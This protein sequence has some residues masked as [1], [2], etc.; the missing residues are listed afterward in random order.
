MIGNLPLTV[1]KIAEALLSVKGEKTFDESLWECMGYVGDCTRAN[2]VY[3]WRADRREYTLFRTY[4]W[5]E[6]DGDNFVRVNDRYELKQDMFEA[7]Q[8][9]FLHNKA[10][11]GNVIDL[12]DECRE[13]F[14]E[15]NHNE[16]ISGTAI[17]LFL[18]GEFWGLFTIEHCTNEYIYSE[19][20]I[21]LLASVGLMIANSIERQDIMSR[22]STE[23]EDAR[24]VFHRYRAILDA[25]PMPITVVDTE[26]KWTFINKAVESL[27][28]IKQCDAVGMKCSTWGRSICNSD[29]CAV[30]RFERGEPGSYFSENNF[31]YRVECSAILDTDGEKMGYVELVQDITQL[32]TMMKRHAEADN[33]N[34]AKSAFLAAMSHEIR[35]P[36]NIILGISEIEM[37]KPSNLP[38]TIEAFGQ[39]RD[40]GELLLALVNDILDISKIEAG[41]ME[42]S[43]NVYTVPTVI[44]ESARLNYMRFE[45]KPI[46]FNI[47]F[48]ENSPCELLGDEL[49]IKQVLN[50]ILSNAF[51]YTDKGEVNLSVAVECPYG[52]VIDADAFLVIVVSD[53]GQG[54]D[55]SQAK[56]C[57]E[58]FTRF[59][60]KANNGIEGTGLG[61][62]ITKKLVITMGG[63]IELDSEPG[64]GSTFTVRIPQK[65]KSDKMSGAEASGKLK[66][67]ALI[68]GARMSAPPMNAIAST[69]ESKPSETM[70]H[71]RVLV[72]D[73][74][75]SNLLVA[76][77]FLNP[78]GVT[79]ETATSAKE[80]FAR[81][82]DEGEYDIIFMDHMMPDI[83]GI[84]ATEKLRKS[85]YSKPIVALTANAIHGQREFFLENGFDEFITKPICSKALRELMFKFINIHETP[86]LPAISKE[87]SVIDI[88]EIKKYFIRDAG[89]AVT[90][91]KEFLAEAEPRHKD[92]KNFTVSAH[93]MKAVLSTI[94]E[95]HLSKE[96]AT[97]EAAGNVRD[98]S[99]IHA[100]TPAM[101]IRLT[102]LLKEYSGNDGADDE[103]TEITEANKH[104]LTV[105]LTVIVSSCEM[106]DGRSANDALSDAAQLSL[107][108]AIRKALDEIDMNLLQSDFDAAS[109]LACKLKESL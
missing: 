102:E 8:R 89:N 66:R 65:I 34:E 69:K 46:K 22:L 4:A 51:K 21:G 12:P 24:K 53:T 94:G 30:A 6:R 88:A 57:F 58:N 103:N 3:I 107:P 32:E 38:D 7:S 106:F 85:G 84:A 45:D 5:D 78:Y 98:A 95:E 14:G 86:E 20:E 70:P 2:R 56:Q 67:L 48:D 80:A 29:N 73:D 35:T 43:E 50:N 40:A 39:I 93:G 72:V 71:A 83:D 36:M 54:M 27:L 91:F 17:P 61:M 105:Y 99:T 101:M 19:E 49:K 109:E 28:G 97:L 82:E 92:Y 1:N 79:V 31:S 47:E 68:S 75:H 33:A 59:N 44:G 10:H 74:I 63:T 62:G 41:K 13:F 96:A 76:K 52:R 42:L 64:R 11:Y 23:F 18:M 55:K 77:G 100:R 81:V 104:R 37:N 90:V 25:I 108:S 87:Q 15:L 60:S 16:V 9:V 26:L